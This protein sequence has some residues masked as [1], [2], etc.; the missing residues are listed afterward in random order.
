MFSPF[1]FFL[2]LFF[3]SFTTSV[4][5][6][7]DEIQELPIVGDHHHCRHRLC[8]WRSCRLLPSPFILRFEA[9]PSFHNVVQTIVITGACR[10]CRCHF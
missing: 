6:N 7:Q 5:N 3:I 4:V 2:S 1:F 8:T 10:C 9:P